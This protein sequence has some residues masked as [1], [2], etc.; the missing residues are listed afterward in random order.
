[1]NMASFLAVIKI[2]IKAKSFTKDY[3]EQVIATWNLN[4]WLTA[5][6]TAEALAYLNEVFAE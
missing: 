1:M 5:E 4:G 2:S 3:Y 6:E